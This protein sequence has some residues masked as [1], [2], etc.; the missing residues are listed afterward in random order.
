LVYPRVAFAPVSNSGRI[1]GPSG[2]F[3][4]TLARTVDWALIDRVAAAS[5]GCSASVTNAR[6]PCR[7][8]GLGGGFAELALVAHRRPAP[9]FHDGMDECAIDRAVGI[10]ASAQFGFAARDHVR[11]AAR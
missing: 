1:A 8:A 4:S 11:G 6:F 2:Y 9:A 10:D 7:L 5:S 3:R